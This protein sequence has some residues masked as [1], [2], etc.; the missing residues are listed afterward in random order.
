MIT[1]ESLIE[2]AKSR[3]MPYTKI[4]GV[5]REYLQVI[6][7]KEIY[8][9]EPGKK[10]YFTGGTYLR[11]LHSLKRFSEDLD[12]NANSITKG[13]FEGLLKKIKLE[14]GRIG[15]EVLIGFAHWGNLYVSK[16]IFPEV[17]KTY[18]AAS[19]YSKKQGIVIKI[20]TNK[21]KY[22]I[23]NEAEVISGF[24]EL[25]PCI[26]TDKGVLFADKIDALTKKE[27]G[28]HIYDIM[29]MLSNKYPIDR[30]ILNSLGF[31]KDP[32]EVIS[33]RISGFSKAELKS[34][35]DVLRPFLFDESEAG[36]VADSQ[37]IIPQLIEKYK[38]R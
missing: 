6:I 12:F 9:T 34:Q 15:I 25:Y 30:S 24:G 35:A 10:L 14:L 27:R 29:F 38:F 20:E 26:C 4:R 8:K 11:L 7:L 37:V 31:K 33:D 36:L 3:G 22:K 21:P 28:R 19:K 16:L 17:E 23:K 2:Q 1:Y 13:E 32:M 18:K 5:L